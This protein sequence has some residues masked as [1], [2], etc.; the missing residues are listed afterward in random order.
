MGFES[1]IFL[2]LSFWFLRE[3]RVS[4][5]RRHSEREERPKGIYTMHI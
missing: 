3:L 2:L 4:F 1:G 5:P